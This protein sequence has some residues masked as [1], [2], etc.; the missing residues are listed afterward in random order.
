MT[1]PA[2]VI[3]ISDSVAAG[4]RADTSG[5][6]AQSVLEDAGYGPVSRDVVPDERKSISDRIRD[7]V[8]DGVPLVVTTGGTGL[9]PRDVTP[10]ATID[11]VDR[12]VPGLAELMRSE[13]LKKTPM[14]A[15]SRGIVGASGRSLV[16]NLPG[17]PKAVTENLTALVPVLGH[18]LDL[19]AGRT[20]HG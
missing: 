14:A 18:A 16:V 15:L 17:S 8:E 9:G 11:V 12:Q 19:L 6:A 20:S 4:T 7:A 2:W 3:T 5:E 13:G 10:E 1:R